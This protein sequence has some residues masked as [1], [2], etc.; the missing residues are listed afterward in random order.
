MPAFS[1]SKYEKIVSDRDSDI[2]SNYTDEVKIAYGDGGAEWK[3]VRTK[4]NSRNPHLW[5][6]SFD[7]L[8]CVAGTL[9]KAGLLRKTY[10]DFEEL[11]WEVK[12]CIGVIR[13]VGA[14]EIYDVALYIGTRLTN[15]IYPQDYVYV[16]GKLIKAAADF[17]GISQNIIN[18][19]RIPISAFDD[20]A[21]VFKPNIAARAL[22]EFLCA[23]ANP[24]TAE[25]HMSKWTIVP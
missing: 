1:I 13:K 4:N 22:E 21:T 6:Y 18:C 24:K 3:S 9:E 11:Y 2:N 19:E 7:T 16:H 25:P 5:I 14:T 8:D 12:K 17:L 23:V 15:P 20:F 10:S